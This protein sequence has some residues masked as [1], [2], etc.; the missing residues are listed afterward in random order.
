VMNAIRGLPKLTCL[1]LKGN[2]CTGEIPRFRKTMLACFPELYFLDDRPAMEVER[3]CAVAWKEGGKEAEKKA[4]DD[5]H[6]EKQD[7]DERNFLAWAKMR[8]DR[9]EELKASGGFSR[10]T[11]S[12]GTVSTS[13]N[14]KNRE[15]TKTA[16][17]LNTTPVTATPVTTTTTPTARIPSTRPVS[18]PA[19][20]ST[21]ATT[22]PSQG[23]N[24]LSQ[25]SVAEATR[26]ASQG[27]NLI[28]QLSAAEA[29]RVCKKNLVVVGASWSEAEDAELLTRCRLLM[30]DFAKVAQAMER[31]VTKD[32]C[33]LR[34]ADLENDVQW[35]C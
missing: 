20:S 1:Y 33:R 16:E 27:P 30:F 22:V 5:F 2:P 21:E 12:Y 7:T 8:K 3:V 6:K 13:E 26:V 23:R 18:A 32:A 10:S 15:E 28:S 34:Y 19:L 17:S 11:V 4:K 31:E 25:L 9:A 35:I 29:T 24:L 14:K